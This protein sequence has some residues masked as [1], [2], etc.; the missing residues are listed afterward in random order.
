[1]TAGIIGCST[2]VLAQSPDQQER[3]AQQAH[4]AFQQIQTEFKKEQQPLGVARE[5]ADYQNHYNTK[6]G[7][8]FILVDISERYGSFWT[9]MTVYLADANER[10]RYAT[11]QWNGQGGKTVSE[12]CDLTP[13]LREKRACKT[14]QEFDAFVT[15]YMEE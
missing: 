6:L 11:Y 2:L 15:P 9:T 7:K 1:M 13:S 14:K 3:C 8:C 10:R 4:R 5:F 12:R